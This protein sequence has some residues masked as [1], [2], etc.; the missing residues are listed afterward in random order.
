MNSYDFKYLNFCPLKKKPQTHKLSTHALTLHST[1]RNPKERPK[2]FG[3]SF[4]MA[5]EIN[6]EPQEKSEIPF[7]L[8]DPSTK[9]PTKFPL[10]SV[11]RDYLR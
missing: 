1:S 6:T 5:E 3:G 2:K 9:F 4:P 11:K 7:S 10:A 8:G